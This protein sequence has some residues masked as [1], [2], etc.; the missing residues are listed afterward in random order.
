[1]TQEKIT[2]IKEKAREPYIL[3]NGYRYN[4]I[5]GEFFHRKVVE[6]ILGKKIKPWLVVHHKDGN[7]LNNRYWNLK[8][9]P[10]WEHNKLHNI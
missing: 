4:P 1:M 9:M 5:T 6:I 3:K 8:L 2:K 10:Y 7:K